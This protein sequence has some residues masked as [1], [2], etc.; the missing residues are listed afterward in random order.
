MSPIAQA[1]Q[2]LLALRR[3]AD[4]H[5]HALGIGLHPGLQVDP[6]CPDV[7]VAPCREVALLPRLIFRLPLCRQPR[8]HRRRQVR[9]VLAQHSR[10]RLLEIARR[11]AAQVQ[12][13]Q[14]RVQ[15]P[16]APR[17]AAESPS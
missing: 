10:Q 8:D 4:Q 9:R 15:T 7:N 6:V 5:Q 14:Q 16:G 11:D 3:G 13:R 2:F 17:P 1:N 12:Q